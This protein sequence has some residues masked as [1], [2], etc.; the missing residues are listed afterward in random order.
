MDKIFLIVLFGLI[1]FLISRSQSSFSGTQDILSDHYNSSTAQQWSCH[2]Q[3][4]RLIPSGH[5]PGS[6][7]LLTDNERKELLVRFIDNG[8]ELI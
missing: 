1:V 4:N 2:N 8:P 7:I 5:L 3:E 6:S